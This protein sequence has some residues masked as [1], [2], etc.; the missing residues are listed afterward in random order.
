MKKCFATLASLAGTAAYLEHHSKKQLEKLDD[1]GLPKIYVPA[2][3]ESYWDKKSISI[4]LGRAVEITRN[5]IPFACHCLVASDNLEANAKKFRNLL[6]DLGPAFIKFGQ[7]L[8]IRPDILPPVVVAELQKL[9][10][11][12]PPYPTEKAIELIEEELGTGTVDHLFEGLDVRTKPFAAASLGQVYK[13]KMRKTGETVALKVQRPDMIRKVSLD[14][15]LL[16]KYARAVEYV[17]KAAM[18][19]GFIAERK[20]Y[21]LDLLDAFATASY[22]ELDY[23]HEAANQERISKLLIPKIGADK[24]H[25]PRVLLSSRKVL[26]SEFIE[27]VQLAK[28][29]KKTIQKLI[30]V[31]VKVYLSQ[32]L[33]IGYFHSDPHPGNLLVDKKGRLVLIDFGLCARVDNIDMKGMT[34][35]VVH[36]MRGDVEGLLEDAI[37]LGFLPKDVDRSALLPI[38]QKIYDEAKLAEETNKFYNFRST[39]RRKRFVNVSADLNSVFFDFPFIVPEYFALITRALIV[40]EGIALTGDP[41]FDIFQA[42]YPYCKSRASQLGFSNMYSIF[43]AYSK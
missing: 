6:T 43:K 31:G 15:Y 9:C 28:S 12:V 11:S 26:V 35:A 20:A 7:M 22:L 39:E 17:K 40:L 16:R 29:N 19:V 33:D 18:R 10:D 23:E 3:M 27:G 4:P 13:V 36:L 8:S 25:I 42:S 14:L 32:L 30:P 34:S 5:V 21:D 1:S 41:S 38:L 37:V 2:Q 24:M